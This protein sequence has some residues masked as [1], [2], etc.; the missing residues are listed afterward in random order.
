MKKIDWT[1]EDLSDKRKSISRQKIYQ[2]KEYW[3]SE[4]IFM[5]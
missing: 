4:R 3:S 5:R 1:R 2:T